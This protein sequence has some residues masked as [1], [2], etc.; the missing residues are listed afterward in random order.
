MNI[1]VRQELYLQCVVTS[2]LEETGL[3]VEEHLS[4]AAS[5]SGDS[6]TLR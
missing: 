6:P 2:A 4:V 1:I 5:R 3:E